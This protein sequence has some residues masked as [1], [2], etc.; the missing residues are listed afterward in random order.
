MLPELRAADDAWADR[1]AGWQRE[2]TELTGEMLA[3]R[4]RA[5]AA[6]FAE[7]GP[8]ASVHRAKGHTSRELQRALALLDRL[9]ARRRASVGP[10]RPGVVGFQLVGGAPI[11]SPLGGGFVLSARGT[12]DRPRVVTG[13]G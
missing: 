6:V 2:E 8:L 12:R 10:A 3:D 7:A 9:Q 1:R 11:R 13:L 4:D 5:V